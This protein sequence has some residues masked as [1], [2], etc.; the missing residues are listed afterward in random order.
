M[1]SIDPF[2]PPPVN[3]F[4]RVKAQREVGAAVI[5]V[6]SW[7]AT[8]NGKTIVGGKGGF[9][10]IGSEASLREAERIAAKKT[11]ESN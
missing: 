4:E 8:L 6:K 9:V 5:P 1:S 10:R 7:S 11:A 2:A 3:E